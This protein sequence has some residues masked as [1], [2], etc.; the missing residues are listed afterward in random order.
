MQSYYEKSFK[1]SQEIKTYSK[2]KD[3]NVFALYK[4]VYRELKGIYRIKRYIQIKSK[5]IYKIKMYI[6]ISKGIYR[7]KLYI[8]RI[9]MQNQTYLQY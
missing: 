6:Q 4:N 1:K 3:Q 8:Y 2:L 7:I 9:K 5:G